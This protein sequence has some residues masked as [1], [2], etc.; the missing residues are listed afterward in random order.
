MYFTDSPYERMMQ[1]PTADRRPETE[2]LPP[3][4][5]CRGCSFAPDGVCLG[6]CWRKFFKK[7][8]GCHIHHQRV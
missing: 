6:I 7:N 1:K 5:P 4:S 3:G 8:T 2:R